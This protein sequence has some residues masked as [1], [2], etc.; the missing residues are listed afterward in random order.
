MRLNKYNL[1]YIYK[2]QDD[3]PPKICLLIK[4]SKNK[5]FAQVLDLRVIADANH[6]WP[7]HH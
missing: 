4:V 5:G 1:V 3:V 2:A 7:A 6:R